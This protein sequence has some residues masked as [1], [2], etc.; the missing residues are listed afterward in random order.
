MTTS[1][2]ILFDTNVLIY[3]QDQQSEFYRQ[4]SLFHDKTS[5]GE[6]NA[7]LSIQN[8]TEFVSV[9]TSNKHVARPHSI[10]KARGEMEKYYLS[11]DFRLIYP[12]DKTF[13]FF[14]KLL[15][16]YGSK[17]TKHI[18][19]IFLTATMLSNNIKTILTAN[20]KDFEMFDEIE[21][22]RLKN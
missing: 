5:G 6:I 2:P 10:E 16:K 9:I 13:Q 21:V 15:K 7:V 22:L 4:A 8:C 12:T 20:Y 3:N 11:E 14:S 18:F 1:N 19:D 17:K